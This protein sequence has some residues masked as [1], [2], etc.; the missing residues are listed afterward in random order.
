[1][2]SSVLIGRLE[3]SCGHGGLAEF[4]GLRISAAF[5]IHFPR[6]ARWQDAGGKPEVR[7]AK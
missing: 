7:L 5:A 4:V 2:S 1:M 6:Y 3:V